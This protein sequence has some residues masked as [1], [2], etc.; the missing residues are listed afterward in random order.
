MT[1]RI[2]SLLVAASL[3]AAVPATA[4]HAA[5]AK[6]L[7]DCQAAITKLITPPLLTN[8]DTATI[9]AA[10]RVQSLRADSARAVAEACLARIPAATVP[11]S[12]LGTLLDLQR[13]V[14]RSDAMVATLRRMLRA[15]GKS[16]TERWKTMQSYGYAVPYTAD[17][18]ALSRDLI[19]LADSTGAHEARYEARFRLATVIRHVDS[20]AAYS[21]VEDLLDLVASLPP[22]E[23]RAHQTDLGSLVFGVSGWATV[24]GNAGYAAGFAARA[25]SLL[26]D[27]PE[28]LRM[29][30]LEF[31]QMAMVGTPAIPFE[32][33]FWI[34]AA[35]TPQRGVM[36]DGKVHL[37]EFTSEFCTAC[38]LSYGPIQAAYERLK[39]RGFEPLFC[40]PQDG[41]GADAVKKYTELFSHYDIAFPVVVESKNR[42][43]T[44]YAVSGIPHFLLIDKKGVV[45][46]VVIGWAPDN[47]T[48]IWKKLDQLLAE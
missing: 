16:V 30:S 14:N 45:R 36:G 6:E 7:R 1:H 42:Y 46:D 38:K 23:R 43:S 48:R 11:D 24:D 18:L 22:D 34:N 19:A 10:I 8:K 25:G 44:H 40:V 20:L 37:V 13:Q 4:Q 17:G 3:C 35:E 39:P 32:S 28:F 33:S 47:Q 2:P 9:S 21:A 26:G 29:A 31:R 27:A 12:S 41:E 5:P 15:T